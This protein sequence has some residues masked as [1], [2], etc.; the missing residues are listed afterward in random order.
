MTLTPQDIEQ[1]EQAEREDEARARWSKIVEQNRRITAGLVNGSQAFY[2]HRVT[3]T[4]KATGATHSDVSCSAAHAMQ[5]YMIIGER[6]ETETHI[7]TC[8]PYRHNE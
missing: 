7:M 6:R 4:E 1:Y 3:I 5:W 8:T 2:T